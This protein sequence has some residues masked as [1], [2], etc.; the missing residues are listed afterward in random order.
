LENNDILRR[1]RPFDISSFVWGVA[2]I[3]EEL[4]RL[5]D[6]DTIR[7]SSFTSGCRLTN[8]CFAASRPCKEE[9][10][11]AEAAVLVITAED[12]FD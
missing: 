3:S 7:S 6:A 9:V 5:G 10:P 4:K 11:N 1:S 2:K 12:Y 8:R